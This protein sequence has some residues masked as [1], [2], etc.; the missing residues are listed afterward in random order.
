MESSH[1]L[2]QEAWSTEKGMGWE[3]MDPFLIP[4]RFRDCPHVPP[5][6]CQCSLQN[7]SPLGYG[8]SLSQLQQ[9]TPPPS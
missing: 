4:L 3:H 6:P 1:L 9:L 5:F 2:P 7:D 8:P